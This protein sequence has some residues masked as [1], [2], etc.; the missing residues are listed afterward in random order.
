MK[1]KLHN[2]VRPL[3]SEFVTVKSMGNITE[4]KWLEKRSKGGTIVKL[5]K[6]EYLD[7]TTGEVK[8][9]EH[10]ETRACD[11][12]QVSKS[13]S[14]LRDLLNTNILD[15]DCCR[16]VTL[17]YAENM[18]DPNKLKNDFKNFNSRMRSAIGH[19][20]YIVCAEPQGRGA[21]HLHVV[22]IFAGK[23]PFIKNDLMAEK[24][25]QGF[26]TVKRLDDVDNV[27]VYL[28]AYLG[29]MELS[30]AAKSGIDIQKYDTKDIEMKD[31][32]GCKV[33]KR[34]IKGARLSMY[35][36][37][38]HL[39]RCSKGIKKPIIQVLREYEATEKVSAAT[40]TFESTVF[41][42]D[43]ETGF[44][45]TINKRYYKTKCRKSKD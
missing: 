39:F 36:P 38:F 23:A 1:I 19:Y 5:S 32:N 3:K 8:Q 42:R 18:K 12:S 4:L 22:M 14:T 27:G 37:G 29:D 43:E 13:L 28:T 33:N 6:D 7:Q 17:T 35:P 45:N 24:W 21:W 11:L 26:V 16:W 34:I 25:K 41:I 31:E 9:F 20:E 40:L 44:E 10:Y 2:N 15:V 30:Q